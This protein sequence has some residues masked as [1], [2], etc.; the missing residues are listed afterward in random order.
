MPDGLSS[1][2]KHTEVGS[3]VQKC[4]LV[5]IKIELVD[6]EDQP[7]PKEKY[8]I[9]LPNG[10]PRE[11][12]LDSKGFARIDGIDPGTCKITFP[13]LDKDAWEKA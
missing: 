9:E 4:P 10:K 6:E 8:R 11:G 3:A 12:I 7:V 5:W 13:N 1:F 2:D